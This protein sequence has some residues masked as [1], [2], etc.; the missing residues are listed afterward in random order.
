MEEDHT[1]LTFVDE[2]ENTNVGH[3]HVLEMINY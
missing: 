1:D 3:N 2:T